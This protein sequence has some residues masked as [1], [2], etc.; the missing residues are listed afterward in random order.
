MLSNPSL[1][2]LDEPTTGLDST[3][4]YQI[5]KTLQNLARKGRTII[6]TSKYMNLHPIPN[7]KFIGTWQ[8]EVSKENHAREEPGKIPKSEIAS[9]RR[10][11]DHAPRP[12]LELKLI[13]DS[14]ST[15]IRDLESIR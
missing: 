12:R 7:V 13:F 14:T 1:L 9:I 6:V 11:E 5:I 15:Q 4:A 2:W 8:G 3:S 10:W